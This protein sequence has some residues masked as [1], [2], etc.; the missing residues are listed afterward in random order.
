MKLVWKLIRYLPL[1]AA[2]LAI[3]ELSLSAYRTGVAFGIV[4]PVRLAEYRLY[5]AGTGEFVDQIETAIAEQDYAYATALYELG[6]RYGHDLPPDLRERAEA[7]W[8]QRAYASGS[9]AAR[10]FV[11]GSVD[12]GAEIAGSLTSDLIGVGDL[13]DFSVQGF[14]YVAGRDY[15]PLLLGLSAVGIGLTAASY[16]S[17][18]AA[19]LP[20]AGISLIKNAYRTRKLSRPL[21]AYFWKTAT[22]LVD[23]KVLKTELA[24]MADEGAV[25]LGRLEKAAAKVLDRQAAKSLLDDAE[26]LT[27]IGRKGGMRSSVA[28]LS[29]ADG[30]K[31]LRKLQRVAGHFGDESH[32]V[33]R[34]L[35]RSVLRVGYGL[36]AVLSALASLAM[37]LIVALIRLPTQLAVRL[38]VRRLGLGE[39]TVQAIRPLMRLW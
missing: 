9:R 32:A 3:W 8:A 6:L 20:D 39:G 4:D 17:A 21:T 12:S 36:Y 28:V 1:V 7:T 30:P 25:G 22:R 23:G 38:L 27:D 11:F 29:L 13:R 5:A 19:A 31:D 18:G 2:S 15:D 24:A 10:G 37:I 34:F 16:G 35:G 14:S 33:F 26:V